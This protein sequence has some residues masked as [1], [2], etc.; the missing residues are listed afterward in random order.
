[1]G[2]AR[3]RRACAGARRLAAIAAFRELA[4]PDRSFLSWPFFEPRHR[5]LAERL[6]D[7]AGRTSVEKAAISTRNAGGSSAS[8]EAPAFSSSASRTGRTAPTCAASRSAAKRSPITTGSPTSPLRCRAWARARSRCSGRSSRSGSGCRESPR[9]SNRRLRHDRA[10]M[11][12][13]RGEHADFRDARRQRMGAGRRKDLHLQWRHRR[14]LPDL[15]PHG[16][17]RRRARPLGLHRA[18]GGGH[19]CRA[20]R[21]DRAPPA[22]PHQI[23]QCPPSRRRH[24]RRARRRIPN[25]D[26][27]PQPVPG[28]GR[29]CGAR[30]CSPGIG[31][32][33]GV[34]IEAPPRQ[35]HACRQCGDAGEARRHGDEHRCLRAADLPRRLAAG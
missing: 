20:H 11:R 23:R 34:R 9:Q 31:R 1:M 7:G 5:E 4:M 27:D 28:D 21:S 24:H 26:G 22:R 8:L 33:V 15:R 13:R 32:G 3:A 2:L 30:L 25:R 29:R 18:G 6:Q 17:R 10:R 35:R 14:L 16:R 12:I 19:R